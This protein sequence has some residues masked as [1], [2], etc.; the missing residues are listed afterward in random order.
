MQ[1]EDAAGAKAEI[2]EEQSEAIRPGWHGATTLR[3]E[4]SWADRMLKGLVTTP[5]CLNLI[6]QITEAAEV[7]KARVCRE[8]VPA[9]GDHVIHRRRQICKETRKRH[10]MS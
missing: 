6:P 5:R 2:R 4:G 7:F 8:L 9:Q 10:E 3:V 1:A